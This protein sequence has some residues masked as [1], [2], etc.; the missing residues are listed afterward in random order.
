M[1]EKNVRDTAWVEVKVEGFVR[2]EDVLKVRALQ[3]VTVLSASAAVCDKVLI[4]KDVL[5]VLDEV[6]AIKRS[7]SAEVA[8]VVEVLFEEAVAASGPGDVVKCIW[9]VAITSGSSELLWA[10]LV[11][12]FD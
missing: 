1:E 12:S 6:V 5:R 11:L 8:A 3:R 2:V 4:V 10:A 7:S 9:I